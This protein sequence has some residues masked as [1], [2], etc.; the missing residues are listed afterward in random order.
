MKS[1]AVLLFALMIVALGACRKDRFTGSADAQLRTAV[2]T[3]HFDTVFVSA[4]STSGVVKIFNDNKEGIRISAVRLAGGNASPFRIN[5]DGIA[6]PEV[7]DLEVA[8]GDSLYVFVTVTVNPNSALLPFVVQDSIAIDWNGNRRWVQL[9]AYGQNARFLRNHEV[10]G[11][12]TWDNTLPYVILD[13]VTVD[14]NAT[15]NITQGTRI[16]FHGNAPMI[17]H[18]KLV[19]SGDRFDS[20]RV[21]FNGDRLDA[22]YRDF[23]AAWPGIYFSGASRNNVLSYT[24]IR[25]AYQGIAIQGPAP[26]TQLTLRETIIDNAYDAGIYATNAGIDSRNLL[27]SNCGSGIVLAGGNYSFIHTTAAG[28]SNR[29]QQHSEPVLFLSNRDAFGNSATLNAVFRNG[30]YWGEANGIVEDEVVVANAAGAP[31][32]V[33]FD[34]ALWRVRTTPA[35]ITVNNIQNGLDPLFDSID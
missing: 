23:P 12:E 28:Y 3:L 31:F 24:S 5:V 33:Q 13:G 35:G 14:T 4:G 10:Q 16:Y 25:N 27:V 19:A 18:G 9:D 2:D 22:P 17:V 34:G 30:I 29:Y 6:G 1:A 7:R 32:N 11:S 26:A 15:L 20:T 21:V 8:G